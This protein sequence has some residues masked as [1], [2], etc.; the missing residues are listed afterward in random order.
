[1]KDPLPKL[2]QD[3]T[4]SPP[5]VPSESEHAPCRRNERDSK[6]LRLEV[7]PKVLGRTSRI[8]GGH[9][10][11]IEGVKCRKYR[12]E[13]DV[14]DVVRTFVTDII[15]YFILFVRRIFPYNS[16]SIS[17]REKHQVKSYEDVL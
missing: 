2:V 13:A 14:V 17:Y 5:Y 15:D 16:I 9:I 12:S 10:N 4:T 1:M 3:M 11:T 6:F 8:W 7:P